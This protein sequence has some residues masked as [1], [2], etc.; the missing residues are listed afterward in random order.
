MIKNENIIDNHADWL[1]IKEASQISGYSTTK[2]RKWVDDRIINSEKMGV[3]KVNI[4]ELFDYIAKIE[5]SKKKEIPLS[6]IPSR[7]ESFKFLDS[8]NNPY[9]TMVNPNRYTTLHKYAISNRGTCINLKKTEEVETS[10]DSNGYPQVSL[11]YCR[12]NQS[13][14]LHRLVAYLWCP[15]GKYKTEVHHIYGTDKE[16]NDANNLIWLTPEEHDL[17]ERLKKGNPKLYHLFIERMKRDNAWTEDIRVIAH[18]EYNPDEKFI[19][20]MYIT[21]KGYEMLQSGMPWSEIPSSEIRAEVADLK[22][23]TKRR[24]NV[25]LPQPKNNKNQKSTV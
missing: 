21:V 5:E 14:C 7:D 6:F 18:P 11:R 13:V 10:K 17:A 1:T 19:Y 2:I 12:R 25:E 15:N 16:N 23:K 24:K 22:Y 4:Q 8:Y 3:A 20:W 9:M